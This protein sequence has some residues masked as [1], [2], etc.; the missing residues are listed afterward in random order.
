MIQSAGRILVGAG[1]SQKKAKVN[2]EQLKAKDSQKVKGRFH[3]HEMPGG[4]F[5]FVYRKYK[6]EPVVQYDL[7]DGEVY[8]IP[9]GVARHLNNDVG[10]WE[11]SY[12]LDNNGK[13]SKMAQTRVRRVSFESLE[14]VDIEDIGGSRIEEVKIEDLPPLD[15]V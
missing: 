9:L 10:R 13:P 14:F 1:G 6:G 7:T 8:E 11:H 5:S 3:W 15:V 2:I 12:L 4:T